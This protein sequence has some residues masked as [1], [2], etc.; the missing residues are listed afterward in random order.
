M[1]PDQIS[2]KIGMRRRRDGGARDTVP[3]KLRNN[4]KQLANMD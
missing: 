3:K 4:I 2:S 1:F